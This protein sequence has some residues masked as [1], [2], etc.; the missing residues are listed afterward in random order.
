[1]KSKIELINELQS[2]EN[3]NVIQAA[4]ELR[5]T[6]KL[7][8]GSLR[9]I[10]LC[11]AQ[12]QGADLHEADLAF[13]D[14][15]Q[16]SLDFADLTDAKLQGVKF[17]RASLQGANFEQAN[18]TSADLY[19]VNLRGA[20]NLTSQQLSKVDQL[21]GS[22]M[23]DGSVYDGRMNLFG[24]ISLARWSKVKVEDPKSMAD[25]YGVSLE[26]YLIGQKKEEP[27]YSER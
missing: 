11:H 2:P 25:F 15:H 16:A 4:N 5:T 21:F 7:T 17:N 23:P 8:D 20:R 24:D 6:G 18:L 26:A 12:L 27:A 3:Q 13:V 9:G 1:M 22:I 14:F 19:K 10:A